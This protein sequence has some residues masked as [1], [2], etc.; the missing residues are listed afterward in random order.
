MS[1]R[2]I[3]LVELTR[4]IG[5][6]LILLT[7]MTTMSTSYIVYS[8]TTADI[9]E[10]HGYGNRTIVFIIRV[11]SDKP[12]SEVYVSFHGEESKAILIETNK[13]TSLWRGI[14]RF[15]VFPKDS[16]LCGVLVV[17]ATTIDNETFLVIK[18]HVCILLNNSSKFITPTTYYRSVYGRYITNTSIVVTI[19]TTIVYPQTPQVHGIPF[20][21]IVAIGIAVIALIAIMTTIII[22]MKSR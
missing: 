2:G 6:L 5:V 17:F 15:S 9:E 16:P 7:I 8:D 11:R 13:S 14:I 18:R 21:T 20:E 19:R 4:F 10:V 22:F 1:A 12:V 3:L